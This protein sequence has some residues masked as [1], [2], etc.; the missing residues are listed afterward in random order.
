LDYLKETEDAMTILE[1]RNLSKYFGGL[2]AAENISFEIREGLIYG[3]IGPNGAGKTTVFNCISRFYGL[4]KGDVFFRGENITNL[5]PHDIPKKGIA[6]TFQNLELF[7]EMSVIENLLVAQHLKFKY[8][9]FKGCLKLSVFKQEEREALEKA[10]NILDFLG[11]Q[12]VPNTLV[13]N[14]PYGTRKLIEIGRALMLEPQLLLLDEPVSGMNSSESDEISELIQKI[15]EQYDLTV[16]L[17]EHNM[18]VVM[19]LCD[20]IYVM[21][22]GEK[23]AEGTPIEIQNNPVVIEAY[24]GKGFSDDETK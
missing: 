7:T 20:Y 2:K 3:L 1:T 17:V 11:L 16:F 12:V 9:L 6:R 13:K 10:E 15:K 5:G 19:N 18:G 14:L 24:L 21:D 8:G 4:D 23:L 22:H